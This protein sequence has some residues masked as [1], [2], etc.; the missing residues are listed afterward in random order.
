MENITNI[1]MCTHPHL[2]RI[3]LYVCA[4]VQLHFWKQP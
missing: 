4:S 1:Y 3:N 2:L